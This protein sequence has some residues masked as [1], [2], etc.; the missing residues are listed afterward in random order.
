MRWMTWQATSARPY[1]EDGA[2][3]VKSREGAFAKSGEGTSSDF[4]GV[5]WDKR[6]GE[7]AGAYTRFH[8]RST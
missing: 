1:V 8:F 3:P 2:A 4:K 7:W 5:S 6:L